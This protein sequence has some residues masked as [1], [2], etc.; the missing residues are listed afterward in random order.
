MLCCIFWKPGSP[1]TMYCLDT[2]GSSLHARTILWLRSRWLYFWP[3]LLSSDIL[4][5]CFSVPS[6]VL[7][8]VTDT[9][10]YFAIL[11][12]EIFPLAQ[13]FGYS[14]LYTDIIRTQKETELTR[15]HTEDTRVNLS[16]GQGCFRELTTIA[17][18]RAWFSWFATVALNIRI[19]SLHH[20]I[21]RCTD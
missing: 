7:F 8:V 6:D 1:R 11:S 19:W 12:S 10:Q 13:F 20:G 14:N 16:K 5:F 15:A 18:I 2:V 4:H 21:T 9:L 3:K 17:V